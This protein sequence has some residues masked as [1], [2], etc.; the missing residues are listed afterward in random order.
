MHGKC[1]IGSFLNLNLASQY[2]TVRFYN[3]LYVA[4]LFIA[5]LY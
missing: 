4:K 3:K 5:L 2:I 1:S